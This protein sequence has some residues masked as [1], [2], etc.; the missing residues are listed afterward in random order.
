MLQVWAPL[1]G[2]EFSQRPQRLFQTVLRLLQ[3]KVALEN[4]ES[5]L[6]IR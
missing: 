5:I 1:W 6:N 3:A 4:D 2:L